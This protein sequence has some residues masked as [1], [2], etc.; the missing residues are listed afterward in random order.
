MDPFSI[1][2]G[3][4]SLLTVVSQAINRTSDFAKSF[5]DARSEMIAIQLQLDQLKNILD[6]L[7]HDSLSE[8][9]PKDA[10]TADTDDHIKDQINNCMDILE[11]LA[12]LMDDCGNSRAKWALTGRARAYNIKGFLKGCITRLQLTVNVQTW[13]ACF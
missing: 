9:G 4:V 7:A 6:L 12:R 2:V 11:D 5:R 8:V 1:T 10:T 3:C 13:Y